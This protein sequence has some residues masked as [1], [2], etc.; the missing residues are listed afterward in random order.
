MICV[1]NLS[2]EPSPRKSVHDLSLYNLQTV[3]YTIFVYNFMGST[4]YND[5]ET[6]TPKNETRSLW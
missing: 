3:I 2:I 6:P 1:I 5:G 4:Q